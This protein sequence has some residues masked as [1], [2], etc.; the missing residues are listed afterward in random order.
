MNGRGGWMQG[1]KGVGLGVYY[2]LAE[3]LVAGLEYYNLRDITTNA[4]NY[5]W[6]GSL[7]KFF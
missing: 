6:W 7:T 4:K 1:F 3:N 5:T 2:T